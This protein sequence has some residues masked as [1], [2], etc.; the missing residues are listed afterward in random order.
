VGD[1]STMS[2]SAAEPGGAAGEV[3]A[4]ARTSELSASIVRPL[5]HGSAQGGYNEEF[6]VGSRVRIRD[7][8]W[9]ENSMREW[10]LRKPLAA[11]QLQS[12]GG[13][14]KPRAWVR[15]L[16]PSNAIGVK[17]KPLEDRLELTVDAPP[18][19]LGG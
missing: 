8:A 13:V 15:L 2:R 4:A 18:P 1:R 5:N 6:P 9:L 17:P 11:E 10:K 12:A 16:P 19:S 14:A 3:L 7:R